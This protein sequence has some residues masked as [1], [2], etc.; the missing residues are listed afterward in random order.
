MTQWLCAHL[1]MTLDAFV[2]CEA[3][4]A[5]AP[6]SCNVFHGDDPEDMTFVPFADDPAFNVQDHL[7]EYKT[8]SWQSA[9][10]DSDLN[11]ILMETARRLWDK[12]GVTIEHVDETGVL[13]RPLKTYLGVS[14]AISASLQRD[15]LNWPGSS[16]SSV[17]TLP[18][19]LPSQRDDLRARLQDHLNLFCPNLNCIQASCFTHNADPVKLDLQS[20]QFRHV[21]SRPRGRPRKQTHESCGSNCE[22]T[23]ASVTAVAAM[24]NVV[25]VAPLEDQRNGKARMSALQLKFVAILAYTRVHAPR[26]HDALASSTKHIVQGTAAAT[27]VVKGAG[28]GVPATRKA[29]SQVTVLVAVRTGSATLSCARRAPEEYVGELIYEPT[30]D[31]RGQLSE[32]RGRSYVYGL[33]GSLNIDS[34]YAGNEARFINH[35]PANTA[36]CQVGIFL[37]NGD[38]RIGIYAK[39]TLVTGTE[40]FLDYGPEFPIK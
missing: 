11:T 15:S 9:H 23:H 7:E 26:R 13:P 21:P 34:T 25:G 32:H 30:F 37:V 31:S 8:F 5:C 33:N 10:E 29:V 35:A 17:S 24:R 1:L 12:Y 39:R 14:G 22:S 20:G 18:D 3:F 16:H 6:L 27:S 38:H 40:L 19:I 36:N 28:R 2:S 4:E